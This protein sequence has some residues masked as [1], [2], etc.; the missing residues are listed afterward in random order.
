MENAEGTFLLG[1]PHFSHGTHISRQL[2]GECALKLISRQ[3]QPAEASAT[4]NARKDRLT[5]DP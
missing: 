1:R 3:Q 4:E 2:K 5:G